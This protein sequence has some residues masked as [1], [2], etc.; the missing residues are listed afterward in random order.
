MISPKESFMKEEIDM[1]YTAGLLDGD[2]SFSLLLHRQTYKPT[3][4]SFYHPCIQISNAFEGMSQFLKDRFAGSLRIK[5]PQKAH[6]KV[7]YV[8]SLRSLSG[9]SS[10]IKKCMPYLILKR[11]QAQL[12]LEFGDIEKRDLM[13]GERYNLK[14]K[15][16]N[17]QVLLDNLSLVN[18]TLID[19][20]D[21]LV[22]AY[23]AGIMD[24]E[25]SFSIKKENPHS[26]SINFR[27]SPMIQLTMVPSA[28]LNFFR[29]NFSQGTFCVPRVKSA[30][31]GFGYKMSIQSKNG[32]TQFIDKINPFLRFK[33][34]RAALLHKFC[35][36]NVRV[37]HCQGGVPLEVL[38]FREEVYQ[39]MKNM[40]A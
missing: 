23:M 28:V 11:N 15:N 34:D 12:M 19:S 39:Q 31:K 6:H 9:C 10:M 38:K 3:W 8:W 24:T 18:Q 33:K 7:L 35:E 21:P 17:R 29:S 27:Y 40:N 1:A 25:G 14:M 30:E 37:R 36:N 20:D 4:K 5:K 16:S 22:W 2:G 26:G 13:I 32:C